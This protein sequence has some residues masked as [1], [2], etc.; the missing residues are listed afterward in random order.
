MDVGECPHTALV[1]C[2][3]DSIEVCYLGAI[4]EQDQLSSEGVEGSPWASEGRDQLSKALV[5]QHIVQYMA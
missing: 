1:M 5:I 2:L 3:G 4:E